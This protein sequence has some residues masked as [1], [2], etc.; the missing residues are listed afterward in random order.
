MAIEYA[1]YE[2]AHT[3]TIWNS[4]ADLE[5]N[6]AGVSDGEREKIT[7]KRENSLKLSCPRDL[8]SFI[9]SMFFSFSLCMFFCLCSSSEFL[10]LY[11]SLGLSAANAHIIHFMCQVLHIIFIT[12]GACLNPI[13]L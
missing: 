4:I 13:A 2:R 12:R 1:N 7:R 5:L 11:L 3:H 10:L 6:R 8:V 9:V